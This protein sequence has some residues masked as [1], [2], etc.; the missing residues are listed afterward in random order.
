VK[1]QLTLIRGGGGKKERRPVLTAARVAGIIALG[2]FALA[3]F[4]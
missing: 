3:V 4:R 2:L 1:V